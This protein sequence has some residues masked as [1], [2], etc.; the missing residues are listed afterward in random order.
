MNLHEETQTALRQGESLPAAAQAHLQ[1]CAECRSYAE[2][3]QRLQTELVVPFAAP[4]EAQLQDQMRFLQTQADRRRPALRWRAFWRMLAPALLLLVLLLGGWQLGRTWLFGPST[5]TLTN[6]TLIPEFTSVPPGLAPDACPTDLPPLGEQ[7]S[8]GTFTLHLY[9][10]CDA[11]FHRDAVDPSDYSL[12]DRLGFQVGYTYIGQNSPTRIDEGWGIAPFYAQRNTVQGDLGANPNAVNR[13]GLFLP[14]DQFYDFTQPQILPFDFLYQ[15]QADTGEQI[16]ALL[17]FVL[18]PTPDGFLIQEVQVHLLTEAEWAEWMSR[19]AQPLPTS[20]P[21]TLPPALLRLQ[22]LTRTWQNPL[23]DSSGWLHLRERRIT[24]QSSSPNGRG[25]P[26]VFEVELWY[27]LGEGRLVL[28]AV[29]QTRDAQGNLIEESFYRDEVWHDRTTGSMA[30]D[31][32]LHVH[33]LDLDFVSLAVKT[34]QRGLPLNHTQDNGEGELFQLEMDGLQFSALFDAQTGQL[35]RYQ[36]FGNTPNGSVDQE[37][38]VL[39]QERLEQPPAEVLQILES[40]QTRYQPP[41]PPEL[42]CDEQHICRRLSPLPEGFDPAG[43]PLC[44]NSIPGDSVE[45][46]TFWY[47]DFYAGDVLLGRLDL[48]WTAGGRAV[49]SPDGQAVAF[50]HLQMQQ[51]QAFSRLRWAELTDL[52]AVQQPLPQLNLVSQLSWSPQ[53]RNLAFGACDAVQC[54]VYRY[55]A[56]RQDLLVL[57]PGQSSD[58]TAPVWSPDGRWIAFVT[59]TSQQWVVADAETGQVLDQGAYDPANPTPI[60]FA[61][62][63]FQFQPGVFAFESCK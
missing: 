9:L 63:T 56:I 34:W 37:T 45:L 61:D 51:G 32:L 15:V 53:G 31:A 41:T 35:L 55:D 7:L 59:A 54:A 25:L 46:P 29:Q 12:I 62:W 30:Q 42:T 50:S 21:N 57:A 36:V 19:A 47:G 22:T 20:A 3:V 49:L 5:T 40:P 13:F 1:T 26:E 10:V 38:I 52:G 16:Q 11:Q 6:P 60:R 33:N 28:R 18:A 27:E 48:G 17:H 23:L 44:L 2:T 43:A 39:V 8:D 4:T 24:N 14:P 58:S